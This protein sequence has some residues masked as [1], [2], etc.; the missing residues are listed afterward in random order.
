[1]ADVS[2]EPPR[3]PAGTVTGRQALLVLV[4]TGIALTAIHSLFPYVAGR[5]AVDATTL[6]L[7][8]DLI[9]YAVVLATV[10]FVIL[11][12]SGWNVVGFRRCDPSLLV[13]AGFLACLW[14]GIAA[15]LYA[16]VG[17]WDIAIA[18]GAQMIAPY[19]SDPVLL[20]GLFVVA[21]PI[22]ALS[23]EVLFRGILYGWLRRRLNVALA[24]ILSALVFAAAHFAALSASPIAGIEMALLGVLL[25]LLYEAGRSLWPGILCHALH[26]M[27]L[28]GLYL[29]QG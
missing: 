27:L 6:R 24:A 10:G 25:A 1:M 17:V 5:I 7:N 15:A 22:A 19:R 23:E 14:I 3:P 29:Y 18:Y 9:A 13:N 28:L 4:A 16:A 21:G 11:I 8:F 26:N 2:G 12:P 20:A